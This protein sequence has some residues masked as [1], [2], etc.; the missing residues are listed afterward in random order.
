MPKSCYEYPSHC[1]PAR[2]SLPNCSRF[3]TTARSRCFGLVGWALPTNP[4]IRR[5][6]RRFGRDRKASQSS[7]GRKQSA[8]QSEIEHIIPT[9][10]GGTNDEDNL[11]LA[12]RLC[13]NYKETQT[14]GQD[15]VSNQLVQLFNPRTQKWDRHLT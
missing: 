15:P 5:K 14:Q 4:R 2:Q 12:C 10:R 3:G 11:W 9:A 6:Y 7:V 13:N 8:M 1:Y